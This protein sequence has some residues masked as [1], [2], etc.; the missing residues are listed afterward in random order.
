MWELSAL[1]MP[2]YLFFCFSV[3]SSR[4]LLHAAGTPLPFRTTIGTDPTHFLLY[5]MLF[6]AINFEVFPS[7]F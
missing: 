6:V 1:C 7:S 4:S 5:N 2:F 3:L